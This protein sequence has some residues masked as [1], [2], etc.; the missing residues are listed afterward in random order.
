[1]ECVLVKLEE[2]RMKE[3]RK[4]ESERERQRFSLP[5]AR[6]LT[7]FNIISFLGSDFL[8]LVVYWKRETSIMR[9][10]YMVLRDS[11]RLWP[12]CCPLVVEFSSYNP[13]FLNIGESWMMKNE[14]DE[15]TKGNIFWCQEE[16]VYLC[17]LLGG[18]F[19]QIWILIVV[20]VQCSHF[21]SLPTLIFHLS[22]CFVEMEWKIK[23]LRSD[24]H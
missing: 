16:L 12:K 3:K 21:S 24:L 4:E 20:L 18:N 19:R 8:F 5:V 23:V 13:F 2:I 7:Q 10:F 17:S 1:L 22:F 6:R 15:R 11:D 14:K 9:T